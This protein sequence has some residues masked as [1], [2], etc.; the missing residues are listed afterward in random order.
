[1]RFINHQSVDYKEINKYQIISLLEICNWLHNLLLVFV[2]LYH[3][4]YSSAD[5]A[6]AEPSRHG[7]ASGLLGIPTGL[8]RIKT[9]RDDSDSTTSRQNKSNHTGHAKIFRSK[10]GS[11]IHCFRVYAL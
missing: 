9:R 11:D 1:M 6:M 8:N 4:N 5:S 10:Q 7:G 3:Y 2:F